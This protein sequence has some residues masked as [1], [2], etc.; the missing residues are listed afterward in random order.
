MYLL[1]THGGSEKRSADQLCGDV[2]A[3]IQ[4]VADVV[5]GYFVSIIIALACFTFI[6]WI[7]LSSLLPQPPTIFLAS[8]S[9]GRLMVCIELF[10]A[11]IVVACPCALSLAAPTA[12]MAGT[13]VGAAH[14][15][16]I[17]GGVALEKAAQ[18]T[19]VVFDK[20]GTLTFG[21]MSVSYAAISEDWNSN[22]GSV[23]LWWTLVG[24]AECRSEHLVGRAIRIGAKQRLGVESVDSLVGEATKFQTTPGL[25][26]TA[27]VDPHAAIS[28]Y[29][30]EVLLGN[31]PFLHENEIQLPAKLVE[32]AGITRVYIA[33]NGKYAGLIELSDEIKPNASECIE[34]LRC[35]NIDV[36]L[37][38]G[39][40]AGVARGTADVIGISPENVYAGKLPGGKQT[41][42]EN[43][44]R[45]G[46]TVAMVGDGINDSPALT[47]AN[48]GISFSNGTDVAVEAASVVLVNPD[49]LTDI[50]SSVH[51]S[52]AIFWRIKA[53][54]VFSCVYNAVALPIATD[55]LLPWGIRLPPLAAS[56][57]MVCSSVTVITSS[58]LLKRWRR[59]SWASQHTA[60]LRVKDHTWPGIQNLVVATRNIM[61]SRIWL[62][63]GMKTRN[64]GRYTKVEG[65]HAV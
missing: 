26:I 29:P 7:F 40:D 32:D 41:I 11:V 30:Y 4:R 33:I 28:P 9:G 21:N 13:G 59:P 24:L 57:A 49:Q 63:L 8:R 19:H 37:V 31:R 43:L 64:R 35:M 12:V 48:I 38:T 36:S 5:A 52:K 27:T 61:S 10:T 15:I 18:V 20:T 50:P 44:Q 58:L 54:L 51:L 60:F 1:S 16:L 53:N 22:A 42:I 34:A 56:A 62:P 65:W 39:D 45:Q 6:G 55:L 3:T 2:G 46:Q 14:G 17:K 47:S 23:Q 25:G